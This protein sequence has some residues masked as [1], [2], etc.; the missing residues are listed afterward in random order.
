MP[1][2]SLYAGCRLPA[3][4]LGAVA[5]LASGCATAPP[6]PS[7]ASDAGPAVATAEGTDEPQ[8]ATEDYTR[9]LGAAG[10]Y[11]VFEPKVTRPNA[12][13]DYTVISDA[14]E[15]MVFNLGPSLRIR[16]R[17]KLASAGTRFVRGH[18]SPYRLEGNK[19]FFDQ[20]D[21]ETI[22]SLHEYVVSLESIGNSGQ[23]P[24]LSR[25]EQLA[26]W[27][28]LHNMIVIDQIAQAYPVE[29][30]SRIK[31]GPEKAPLHEAKLVTIQGVPL[32]LRDIR[33]NI[34]YRYWDDPRVIY[35]F[36]H[37]DLG[38]PSIHDEAYTG[39]EIA[40]QLDRSGREFVNALRGVAAGANTIF[41]SK[42]YF[43]ARAGL[44]PNWPDDLKAHLREFAGDDV[45]LILDTKTT[46]TAMQY[47]DT[48]ADLV[49]G[50]PRHEILAN[51]QGGGSV[52][53]QMAEFVEEVRL[54]FRELRQRGQLGAR[55]VIIDIPTEDE[56]AGGIK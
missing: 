26:Y 50:D 36:F 22:A 16:A 2:F 51:L 35:G 1:D 33:E 31:I 54:K 45:R 8:A 43:E 11:A 13:I 23:I 49:G 6:T 21:E 14:L 39:A 27:F 41:V 12:E 15:L 25:D 53:P 42:H 3:L 52:P 5:L 37:G 29:T 38:S 48:V 10:A 46:V 32:S 4:A 20:F 18:D 17:P 19:I 47:P 24:T 28:N 40:R 56:S 55:V 34:V 9:T 7:S 30:P 44:F